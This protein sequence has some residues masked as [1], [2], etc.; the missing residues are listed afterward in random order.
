MKKMIVLSALVLFGFTTYAAYASPVPAIVKQEKT[1]K[2]NGVL[3][4]DGTMYVL[5]DGTKSE[6][7]KAATMSNGTKVLANG[8]VYLKNGDKLMLENG[9][10]VSNSGKIEKG[11]P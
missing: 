7:T 1:D 3:M 4:E 2:R 5:K 9:D 10:F 8:E 11:K 6:M